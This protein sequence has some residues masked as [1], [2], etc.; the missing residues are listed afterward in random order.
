MKNVINTGFE[1]NSDVL[2]G[3]ITKQSFKFFPTC[4]LWGSKV[5]VFIGLELQKFVTVY[6]GNLLDKIQLHYGET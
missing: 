4:V 6:G 5:N 2:R 1:P 3:Q